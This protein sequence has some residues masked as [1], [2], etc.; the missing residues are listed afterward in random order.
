VP[1]PGEHE[2]RMRAFHERRAFLL[3]RVNRIPGMKL[4]PPR[5]AFYALIDVRDFCRDRGIDDV[6][7][8][9]R[10]L[11]RHLLAAVPG[12]AFAIPGF[13]RLSYAASMDSLRKAADRLAAFAEAK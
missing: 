13:V 12:S 1:V 9:E 10:L 6:V 11:D 2:K 5:G 4:A 8:C 7:F 3:D